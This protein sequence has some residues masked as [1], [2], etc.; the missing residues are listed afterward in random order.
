MNIRHATT[1]LTDR[2][3]RTLLRALPPPF[4][5]IGELMYQTGVRLPEALELRIKDLNLE[6]GGLYIRR[7][8]G[9]NDRFVALP[10]DLRADLRAQVEMVRRQHE[11]D[12][13]AHVGTILPIG[14]DNVLPHARARWCWQYL[15]PSP[16]IVPDPATGEPARAPLSATAFHRAIQKAARRTGL[17][18]GIHSHSLRHAS[19]ARLIERGEDIRHIQAH[20]GHDDLQVTIRYAREVAETAHKKPYLLQPDR[21]WVTHFGREDTTQGLFHRLRQLAALL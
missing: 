8:N 15:F 11:A 10:A 16:G 1:I 7:V 4:D 19:A 14:M 20:L 18:E 13:R 3:A 12:L 17:G 2:Q 21:S 6:T 9:A 5:L